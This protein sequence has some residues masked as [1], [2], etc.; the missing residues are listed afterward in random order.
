[1]SIEKLR[2]QDHLIC[3]TV[4]YKYHTVIFNFICV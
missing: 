1:V 2:Y 3:R 4:R